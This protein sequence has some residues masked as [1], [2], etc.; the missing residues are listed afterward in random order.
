MVEGRKGLGLAGVNEG[1]EE[2]RRRG[3]GEEANALSRLPSG[4]DGEVQRGLGVGDANRICAD[5]DSAE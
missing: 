3:G 4:L 5:G 2:R 1:G